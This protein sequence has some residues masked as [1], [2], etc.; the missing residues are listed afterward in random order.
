MGEEQSLT[1][2][3]YTFRTTEDAKL[4]EREAQ[5][6]DYIEKR[7][8]YNRTENVLAVYKKALEEKT[9]QTPVGISYLEKIHD[10]LEESGSVMEEIPP[11]PLQTH[12]SRT[13]REQTNPARQ[14]VKTVKKKDALK[15][16]YR[17]SVLLNLLLLLMVAAMFAI[18]LNAKTPN[19]LNYEKTLTNKYAEW[20][21]ELDERE[22]QLREKEQELMKRES[23]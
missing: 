17:I 11:I 3:G 9:F 12:F 10:F 4:A 22:K 23:N 5:K 13:V 8:N 15:V 19:M 20:E 18:A 1:V 6:I 21:Q 16:K 14:R 7:L 2:R